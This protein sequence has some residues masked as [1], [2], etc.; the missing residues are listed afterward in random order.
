MQVCEKTPNNNKINKIK[1]SI[2]LLLSHP[3]LKKHSEQ[4]YLTVILREDWMDGWM[5]G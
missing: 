2:T 5:A 4:K 3:T 1:V